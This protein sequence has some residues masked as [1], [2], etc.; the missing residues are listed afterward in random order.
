VQH[1]A[2]ILRIVNDD[3]RSGSENKVCPSR[4]PHRYCVLGAFH[5]TDIWPEKSES[6]VIY[7]FRMEKVDLARKSWWAPENEGPVPKNQKIQK[8]IALET[9]CNKCD[10]KSKQ[11][12]KQGWTCLNEEC[13][14]FWM[15]NNTEA[16][17]NLDFHTGILNQRKHFSG[18]LPP[19]SVV[20]KLPDVTS[21]HMVTKQCWKGIVCPKCG[22][23]NQ[24][25][26]WAGWKCLT[27]DCDY[28]LTPPRYIIPASAVMGDLSYE[29]QG[30]A[31]SD[32]AILGKQVTFNR[33]THG[34]YLI[35]DYHLTNGI[36]VT[37]GHSNGIIN[38]QPGGANDAFRG[39]QEGSLGLRRL[40]LQT[41]SELTFLTFD[42]TFSDKFTATGSRSAHFS[43]DFVSLLCSPKSV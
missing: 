28:E 30:H 39:L 31:I 40:L 9:T 29:Y 13:P 12:Y 19:F 18:T 4:V 15:I 3:R 36:I 35:H 11:V 7:K 32:D 38:S 2:L 16:P 21:F 43:K 41:Q 34:F 5:V 1:A 6:C 20:P 17:E 33:V 24:R 14:W 37:H 8:A 22:G 42:D 25:A 10:K 26:E 23:C 27:P